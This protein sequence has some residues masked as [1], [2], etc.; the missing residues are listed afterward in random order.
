M[1]ITHGCRSDHNAVE[2]DIG[3]ESRFLPIPPAFDAPVEGFSSEY[4]HDV[5]CGKTRMAWLLDGE[6]FLKICLF[7]L[8]DAAGDRHRRDHL[9]VEGR[10]TRRD[11]SSWVE[12]RGQW[13]VVAGR[14]W[15]LADDS[16]SWQL[17]TRTHSQR[18]DAVVR[19]STR[20]LSRGRHLRTAPSTSLLSQSQY[21]PVYYVS[22]FAA[23]CMYKGGLWRRA[24]SVRHVRVWSIQCRG[25]LTFSPSEP[26]RWSAIFP[27]PI[28]QKRSGNS[29]QFTPP[30]RALSLGQ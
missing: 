15:P 9:V 10:R 28:C 18:L 12:P 7:V 4:C 25:F 29:S 26:P 21:Q 5:W 23:R 6:I 3:S 22:T 19:R 2:P 24:M 8:T 14:C 16:V 13:P 17:L 27:H 20:T 11:G 1:L 30:Q